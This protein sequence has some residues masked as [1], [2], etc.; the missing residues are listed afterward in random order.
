MAGETPF[1]RQDLSRLGIPERTIRILEKAALIVSTIERV[2]GTET[3][4]DT[5]NGQIDAIS[6]DIEDANL[7]LTSLDARV[8][9]LEVFEAD[10]PY[11]KTAGDTMSGSL[12]VNALLECDTFRINVAPTAE[13]VVCTHTLT[14]N[15]NGTA[16]K[17]PI[18][19]A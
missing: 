17:V 12:N 4:L 11:V 3:S 19:A 15:V 6:E 16:Y 5:V 9:T 18:V 2:T 7:S 10:G 14:I 8:D 13:T 1:V